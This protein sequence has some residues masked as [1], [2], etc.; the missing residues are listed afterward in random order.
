MNKLSQQTCCLLARAAVLL[1]PL[2]AH[3]A[4]NVVPGQGAFEADPTPEPGSVLMLAAGL[5]VARC[6]RRREHGV[7]EFE[8]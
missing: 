6:M 5:V 2:A 8:E 3:G 4:D 7:G 1:A